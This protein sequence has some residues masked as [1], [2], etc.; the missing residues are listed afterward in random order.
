MAQ[1]I[2]HRGTVEGFKG[3]H[4]S[5][6]IT[7]AAA[8]SSCVAKKLCNSSESKEKLIDV[9]S[10]DADDYCIGELVCLTG[11]LE[12]GLTAVLCAYAYPLVLLLVVLLSVTYGCGSEPLGALS[13]LGSVALY[14][15]VLYMNRER[16]TR[17]FLFTIKHIKE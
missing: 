11:T 14:Y 13:A 10:E 3:K 16:L 15:F 6:R 9:V 1:S 7:Q 4:I 8:C 5:V 12:S 2:T 17:R